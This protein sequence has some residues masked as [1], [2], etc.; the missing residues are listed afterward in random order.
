MHQVNNPELFELLT[1]FHDQHMDFGPLHD[2]IDP[3]LWS[4]E[5]HLFEFFEREFVTYNGAEVL[6]SWPAEIVK[7]QAETK[8]VLHGEEYDVLP[9]G[10]E[11]GWELGADRHP[12]GDC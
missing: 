8:I 2:R 5:A 7:A 1:R 3:E 12:C 10:V 11:P 9:Y 4:M 6:R